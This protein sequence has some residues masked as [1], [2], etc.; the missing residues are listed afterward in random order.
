MFFRCCF[1]CLLGIATQFTLAGLPNFAAATCAAVK[2]WAAICHVC[3]SQEGSRL[4]NVS[5]EANVKL[6]MPHSS[7]CFPCNRFVMTAQVLKKVDDIADLQKE[8]DVTRSLQTH[9]NLMHM[10]AV[11]TD[12]ASIESGFGFD[13]ANCC[14]LGFVL[15]FKSNGTL[16]QYL[17]NNRTCENHSKTI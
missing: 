5:S 2:V 16:R 4:L 13:P 15:P 8:L 12:V 10:V 14:D 3:D 6:D 9:P 11:C 17:G 1:G 7:T